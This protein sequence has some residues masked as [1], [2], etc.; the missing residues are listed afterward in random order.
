MN[1][2]TIRLKEVPSNFKKKYISLNKKLIETHYFDI[3][4]RCVNKI[5]WILDQMIRMD[6]VKIVEVI[7]ALLRNILYGD[8]SEK[9]RIFTEKLF[10]ILKNNLLWLN[11]QN[12]LPSLIFF[13]AVRLYSGFCYLAENLTVPIKKVLMDVILDLWR[14]NK[15]ECISMGRDLIRILQESFRNSVFTLKIF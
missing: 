8:L 13:K 9:T 11:R 6:F 2:F 5:P 15:S 3:K 12:E 7:M 14:N 10:S 1:F 4:E